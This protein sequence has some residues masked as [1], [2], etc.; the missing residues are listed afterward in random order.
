MRLVRGQDKLY[1]PGSESCYKTAF[2]S[3]ARVI[4]SVSYAFLLIAFVALAFSP[5]V[6]RSHDVQCNSAAGCNG[7]I[8]L[9]L[10][11]GFWTWLHTQCSNIF[12]SSELRNLIVCLLQ[13]STGNQSQSAHCRCKEPPYNCTLSEA[14]NPRNLIPS[15]FSIPIPPDPIT[16]NSVEI[17]HWAINNLTCNIQVIN[18]GGACPGY[19]YPDTTV[20]TDYVRV[21]GNLDITAHVRFIVDERAY[22]GGIPNETYVAEFRVVVP[23]DL[24]F[25]IFLRHVEN[26]FSSPNISACVGATL[27]DISLSVAY[28]VLG[29]P[30]LI[31]ARWIVLPPDTR[32]RLLAKLIAFVETQFRFQA[33]NQTLFSTLPA[34][35][36]PYIG[37][38]SVY[39]L[40]DVLGTDTVL[41]PVVRNCKKSGGSVSW[42][43][44]GKI[45]YDLGV[46]TAFCTDPGFVQIRGAVDISL[47]YDD[48]PIV[49]EPGTR[50][51]SCPAVS[52]STATPCG[53][54]HIC[55]AVHCSVFQRLLCLLIDERVLDFE[56]PPA[57]GRPLSKDSQG[58]G[59]IIGGILGTCEFWSA[60]IPRIKSF[61]PQGSG[62]LMGIRAVPVN[63]GS[64]SCGVNMQRPHSGTLVDYPVDI[65]LSANFDFEFWIN[66]PGAGG[67]R[68]LFS[69]N[70]LSVSIGLNLAW[71]RCESGP[72]CNPSLGRVLYAGLVIDPAIL[73]IETDS[74]HP[75]FPG[76][77]GWASIVADII[78]VILSGNLFGGGWLGSQLLPVILDPD[79]LLSDPPN[80][81]PVPN[82][83]Y[84]PG[85]F[86]EPNLTS[87]FDV[88]NNFFRVRFDITGSTTGRWFTDFVDKH[89]GVAPPLREI[90]TI[91]VL[92]SEPTY[93]GVDVLLDSVGIDFPVFYYSVDGGVWRIHKHRILRLGPF[94]E[95]KHKIRVFAADPEKQLF[96]ETPVEIEFFIDSFGPDIYTNIGDIVPPNFV[97][98]VKTKDTF[99]PDEEVQI[100]YSIDESAF[101]DWTYDKTL[102]LPKEGGQHKIV[103]RARDQKGNISIW[104]KIFYV[105]TQENM[106]CS[107]PR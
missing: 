5:R 34:A 85:S 67:W 49:G 69:F 74:T 38:I 99:T 39:D 42:I 53:G 29:N 57:S 86:G 75:S 22:Q 76:P 80:L 78:G 84:T 65:L 88:H 90:D 66:D 60:L 54:S 43:Q 107:N 104:E 30:V 13:K 56:D 33:F 64:V 28:I 100:S 3:G 93:E 12:A 36:R 92:R 46:E 91:A 8:W 7:S 21:Y 37:P 87:S 15:P 47:D 9:H 10:E 19:Y 17:I 20:F 81:N 25:N 32:P 61:C 62:K 27:Q 16:V 73:G 11:G 82:V 96:D 48:V 14:Y 51:C 105:Q 31:Q 97:A 94:T 83:S 4:S 68:R 23:L 44:G 95:G 102:V 98:V 6:V 79:G 1:N 55:A 2:G 106:G 77:G 58:L 59:E 71:W 26:F 103:I 89:I 50:G 41:T 45:Y 40:M 24:G 101:S 70:P 18:G 63:C 35:Q 52:G 72:R